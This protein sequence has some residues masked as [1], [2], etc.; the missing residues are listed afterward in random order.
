MFYS[1]RDMQKWNDE[2][3]FFTAIEME[4]F[5]KNILLHAELWGLIFRIR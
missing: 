5:N 4:I 2:F 3:K 1:A